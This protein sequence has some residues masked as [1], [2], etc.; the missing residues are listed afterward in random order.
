ML[1]LSFIYPERGGFSQILP[2]K[3][4]ISS[5]GVL[6]IAEPPNALLY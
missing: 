4:E 5:L 2:E 1:F 3:D 6:G